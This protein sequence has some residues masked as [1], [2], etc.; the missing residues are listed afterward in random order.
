MGN[1]NIMFR[2]SDCRILEVKSERTIRDILPLR[3]STIIE[4]GVNQV[5][6]E[7]IRQHND[8]GI[9]LAI[10][11]NATRWGSA[12]DIAKSVDYNGKWLYCIRDRLQP[13][14]SCEVQFYFDAGSSYY[15]PKYDYKYIYNFVESGRSEKINTFQ[16]QLVWSLL[17]KDIIF[18][19]AKGGYVSS[20]DYI[21]KHHN[22]ESSFSW[23]DGLRGA[24]AGGH[25][26]MIDLFRNQVNIGD[27]EL[28]DH[29]KLYR[30]A[31][32]GNVLVFIREWDDFRPPDAIVEAA[33]YG[34][35]HLIQKMVGEFDESCLLLTAAE[36]GHAHICSF[37][38]SNIKNLRLGSAMAQSV[39][40]HHRDVFIMLWSRANSE[41]RAQYNGSA[42]FTTKRIIS[43]TP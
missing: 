2:D 21:T 7:A 19:A 38:L 36:N 26:H 12:L 20:I 32:Q 35:M 34:H 39:V 14:D 1:I 6:F 31:I 15:D 33:R 18:Y 4:R 41:L 27:L 43:T 24:L 37:I 5:L 42:L 28:V 40:N 10:T 16:M 11:Y 17:D 9:E 25:P 23:F 22:D 3:D 13:D 29:I 30:A 8:W